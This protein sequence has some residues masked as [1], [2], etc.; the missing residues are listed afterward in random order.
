MKHAAGRIFSAFGFTQLIMI[1]AVGTALYLAYGPW[2]WGIVRDD[3]MRKYPEINHIDTATLERWLRDAEA[4]KE[5][6]GPL[7]LDVRSEAEYRVSHLPTALNVK[8]SASPEEMRLLT[9]AEQ[10]DAEL[11]RPIVVYCP[12]GMQS[13]EVVDRLTHRKFTRVQMLEGGIFRWGNERRPLVNAE[14]AAVTVVSVG[15]SPHA[16]LLNW[17]V[18]AKVP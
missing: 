15:Q 9:T 12:V 8:A 2:Q 17:A 7:I 1:V 3:L 18:R 5:K 10:S 4:D 14:G 6:Q 13:S 11:K 16:G